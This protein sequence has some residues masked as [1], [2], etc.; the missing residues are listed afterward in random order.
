VGFL[1]RDRSQQFSLVWVAAGF[2]VFATLALAGGIDLGLRGFAA[3]S[4]LVFS[5]WS[6]RP[7]FFRWGFSGALMM[8]G[9][10]EDAWADFDLARIFASEGLGVELGQISVPS[11]GVED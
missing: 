11:G 7:R 10:D 4:A 8:E 6:W 5:F 1:C 2:A 3:G 9:W